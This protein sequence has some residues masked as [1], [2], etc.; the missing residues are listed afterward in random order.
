MRSLQQPFCRSF[1]FFV[2]VL[3]FAAVLVIGATGWFVAPSAMGALSPTRAVLSLVGRTI[4]Q[5][6]GAWVVEYRLRHSGATGMIVTSEEVTLKV[7]GW[8]S[9]SRVANHAIPRWSYL[10]ISPGQSWMADSEVIG[11]VDEAHRCREHLVLSIWVEEPNRPKRVPDEG[12]RRGPLGSTRGSGSMQDAVLTCSVPAPFSLG[13]GAI[14][15]VR[16]RFDH[17]HIFFGE[18]DPL[19]GARTVEL[20]V[21]GAVVRDVV[22]LDREQYL[23]Q[24]KF[25]WPAPSEERRDTHHAVSGPDS[26]HLEAH[27]PGHQY[28]RFPERPVRY[29]TRMKL[30]FWYLIATGTEGECRMRLVQYKDTPISWRML[31]RGGIEQPLNIVGR[32]TKVERVIQTDSEA[33]LV[34]L[35]FQIT[36]ESDV[37]EMWIDDVSLEPIGCAAPGGP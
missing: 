17:Q 1:P 11:A 2:S 20:L 31:D 32:W 6:Q 23:A 5:D 3:C 36:G 13:P 29:N 33:N 15:H 10:V 8:I 21:G 25:S 24:P 28:Y 4:A 26:L 12:H 34:T 14:L 7:E 19:L 22:P 16:L 30:Q 27:V 9:N 18:Y 35:D 37:G